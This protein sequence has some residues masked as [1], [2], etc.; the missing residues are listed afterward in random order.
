[1][2]GWFGAPIYRHNG[3]FKF[4]S[5]NGPRVT[6]SS[7]L[8]AGGGVQSLFGQCPNVG[9]DNS[10]GSSLT[11]WKRIQE[12]SGEVNIHSAGKVVNFPPFDSLEYKTAVFPF[13]YTELV[14][15]FPLNNSPLL[16]ASLQ[17][18]DQLN[19]KKLIECQIRMGKSYGLNTYPFLR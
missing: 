1:M 17:S 9:G 15:V 5:L 3:D 4:F 14:F 18:R 19:S 2:A 10:N 6:Q 11:R 13:K 12:N 16:P 8:S 7:R